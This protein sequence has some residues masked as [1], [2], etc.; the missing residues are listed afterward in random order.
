MVYIILEVSRVLVIEITYR[1]KGTE[2]EKKR[3]SRE[4]VAQTK[5]TQSWYVFILD[6]SRVLE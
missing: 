2:R 5:E 1:E 6:V 4:I 3:E